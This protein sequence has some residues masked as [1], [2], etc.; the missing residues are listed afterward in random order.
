M[1]K[2]LKSIDILILALMIHC[3]HGLEAPK[4]ILLVAF[5]VKRIILE[6]IQHRAGKKLY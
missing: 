1:I 2:T 5:L 3:R 4:N 6:F